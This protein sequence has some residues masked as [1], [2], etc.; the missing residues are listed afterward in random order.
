MKCDLC[1][2]EENMIFVTSHYGFICCECKAKLENSEEVKLNK[3][4]EKIK[5]Y[6]KYGLNYL[7]TI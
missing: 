6:K 2:K 7:E 3:L 1:Q 5:T 4:R